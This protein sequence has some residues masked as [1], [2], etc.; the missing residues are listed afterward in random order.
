MVRA[1]VAGS[2]AF[3]SVHAA[4]Q[5][6]DAGPV[7]PSDDPVIRAIWEEGVER[8]QV[9]ELGHVM[10]DVIGPRLTGSP[11]ME[12]ANDWA[13]R[14]FE[15]WGIEAYRERYGTWRGW[16]RGI[17]HIDLVSP[18]VRTLEGMAAAWSPA[19]GGPV[20][21]GVVILADADTP[22]A[23]EAWLPEARGKFVLVSP[24]VASCRPQDNLE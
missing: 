21:A 3:L 1:A 15:E 6:E 8:S 4:A 17:S 10:M 7:F 18:R 5:E 2:L 11:G 13:V 16:E 12:A 20:E 22:E 24:P 9:M 19:T 14:K 23:F